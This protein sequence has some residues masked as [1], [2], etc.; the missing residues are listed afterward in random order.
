MD[1][2][3]LKA[4]ENLDRWAEITALAIELRTAVL[5]R[6]MSEEEAESRVWA[7]ILEMKEAAWDRT[8]S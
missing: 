4:A 7:E 1:D 6:D 5:A 8:P 2:L 3:E